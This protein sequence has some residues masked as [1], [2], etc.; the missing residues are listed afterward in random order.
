MKIKRTLFPLTMT[1][2]GTALIAVCAFIT[3]TFGDLKFTLQL[4]A[5]LLISGLFPPVYAFASL[6]AYLRSAALGVPV[7]AGFQGGI[8]A[9]FGPTGGFL[10]GFLPSFLLI[11]LPLKALKKPKFYH[12]L[13]LFVGEVLVCYL[14]GTIGL[15]IYMPDKGLSYI[16][17]S[18]VIPYILPDCA[19]V[20]LSAILVTRLRPMIYPKFTLSRKAEEKSPLL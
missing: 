11:S 19:K 12:I 7:F 4:F 10:L 9:L 13:L 8:G 3:L 16:L 1:A 17:L 14:A 6:L 15:Y 5:V 2:L 20:I 18:A